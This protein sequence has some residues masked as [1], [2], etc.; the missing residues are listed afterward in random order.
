MK[1]FAA[2]LA[3][4]AL[5]GLAHPALAQTGCGPEALGTSRTL[6]LPA[7]GGAK[8]GKLQYAETPLEPG[9]VVLTFD[10]GPRPDTTSAVLAALKAHCVKA[11]FFMVGIMV[12]QHPDIART[13]AADGHT[14]GLHAYRHVRMSE[15]SVGDQYADWEKGWGVIRGVLNT[16]VQPV[17]RFPEFRQSPELVARAEQEGIAVLSAD[18][19]PDD[20]VGGQ[21][22]EVIVA[23]TL[24]AL[25]KAGRKGVILLHDYQPSTAAAMP[26]LLQAL[27][28]EGYKVVDLRWR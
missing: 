7:E 17:Y 3:L 26:A 27:K 2:M 23:N 18:A 6:T 14:I 16:V 21:A 5:C 22:P 19:S 25:E 12:E 24:A 1:R 28:R 20:W 15:L 11:T 4:S 13:V 9:E 8:F 10:D